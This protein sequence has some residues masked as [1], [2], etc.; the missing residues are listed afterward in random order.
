MCLFFPLLWHTSETLSSSWRDL[1]ASSTSIT[2]LY[3][4]HSAFSFLFFSFLF[5]SFLFFSGMYSRGARRGGWSL[6]RVG[7]TV[8]G[9]LQGASQCSQSHRQST[10][11]HTRSCASHT[12]CHSQTKRKVDVCNSITASWCFLRGAENAH[13]EGK[14][15][16]INFICIFLEIYA[17]HLMIY[18][19]LIYI[20]QSTS[21]FSLCVE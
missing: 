18:H 21:Q 7:A 3:F 14:C 12:P 13:I 11:T 9:G 1:L 10:H 16:F 2:A 8:W 5:F 17:Q 20:E 4:L 19:A 6:E 15:R